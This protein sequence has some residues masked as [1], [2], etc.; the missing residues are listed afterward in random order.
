[1]KATSITGPAI[2][3]C[4]PSL[5]L[6]KYW[7]KSDSD[8]NLPA[9]PSLAL[10]LQELRTETRVWALTGGR[11]QVII[12]GQ[13]Q[14]IGR[15]VRFFDSLRT[16]IDR[17]DLSF[18]V[19]STNNFPTAAGLA[20]SSSGFAALSLA[21][22]AAADALPEAEK[23]GA[24]RLSLASRH[25][26]SALARQG[27]G[28]AARALYGG[29]TL[30]PANSPHAIPLKA[31]SHW[32]ELRVIVVRISEVA[33][34]I[35]S[36]AAMEKTRLSSPYYPAWITDAPLI[37]GAAVQA[38]EARD[39]DSLGSLM[40]QSYLRMFATMFA[41]DP[42]IIYWLPPSLAVIQLCAELRNAGIPAWETMD[43][44]PQVKIFTV[45][46]QVAAICQ[47]LEQ[48][49]PGREFLIDQGG[50]GPELLA[51]PCLLASPANC[52]LESARA[53]GLDRL[54]V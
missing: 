24:S 54:P 1:M 28:S 2:A 49:Q 8:S 40:R 47:A 43:A 7:G 44:G 21:A 14:E 42:P 37:C 33:K 25:R 6:I 15:F 50:Q 3:S 10:S 12:N 16:D 34:G 30:L 48:A 18:W 20:S 51:A 35:S 38:L 23:S 41:A 45:D 32:P 52:L 9:T 5:A 31:A 11:D 46:T 22:M 4:S 39:L 13:N 36:R 17:H 53:A 29:F 27:S 26:L 19:E